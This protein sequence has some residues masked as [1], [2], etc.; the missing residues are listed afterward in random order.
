[1][2]CRDPHTTQTLAVGR[3]PRSVIGRPRRPDTE[4]IA[5]YVTP[6]C[7]RRFARWIG[8]DRRVQILSRLHAVW[9]LPAD[10]DLAL[11]ARWF[12]CDALAYGVGQR[13]RLLPR[14]VEAVLADSDALATF[15]VCSDGSPEQARSVVVSCDRPRHDWR[16]FAAQRLR[17]GRGDAYPSRASLRRARQ[18]CSNA[19][20]E[21][22]GFPLKW[23]Y[24][25][26]PPTP[27]AWADGARHGLCWVPVR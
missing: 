24:G 19:S 6:R 5:A 12:R 8:G 18:T 2:S 25:W 23:R 27:T 21:E 15:G 3:L 22:L 14:T 9:F 7:D 17:A 10:E 11:G 20:R 16:A 4:A 13:P 1:V 26:Q